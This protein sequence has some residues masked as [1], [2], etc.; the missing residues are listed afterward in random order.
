MKYILLLIIWVLPFSVLSEEKYSISGIVNDDTSKEAIISA[1]VALYKDS[2]IN[3]DNF[4]KGAYSNKFGF[5]SLPNIP[6]GTYYLAVSSVGYKLQFTKLTVANDDVR[7][8]I[9]LESVSV[10]TQELTVTADRES[11]PTSSISSIS[12]SPS[13]VSKMPA[14]GG[15]VD[16][17]R[18]LQLLPGIAAGSELSSG[19]YVRGGSPDQNLIL[20][21][22]VTVYNPSHLAGFISSFNNDAIKD[23][24]MI[25]GA[26]PAEYGGRL[27]SVLDLTMKEGRKD[28]VGG[29]AGISLISSK[30]TVEGPINENSS[31][32][33]SGRR[34]YFDLLLGLI[35]NDA[36]TY[37]F[38]DF[39]AKANYKLSDNDVLYVSGYFARD[40]FGVNE[41]DN[42]DISVNWG[43]STANIRWMHIVNP[44][45][46]T[47]FSLVYTD[48]IFDSN[49]GEEDVIFNTGS[50]IRD[51]VLKGDAQYLAYDDHIIKTGA[52][53]TWHNFNAKAN[54]NESNINEADFLGEGNINTF[55]I[56]LYAQDEWKATDRLDV[57]YGLRGYYFQQGN[58]LDIEPRLSA[59][60]LTGEGVRLKGAFAVA[61]QYIHLVVRN[62]IS[63][64]TDLWF[65]S[66]ENIL[67]SRSYQGV[68][69]AEMNIIDDTYLISLE[70][71]YKKMDNLLEYRDDAEFT[72]GIPLEE[73]FTRGEGRAYGIELFL[74]K[75]IG[76]FTGWVGY[77]LAWTKRQF[78]DLNN[79]KEFYPRYDRRHDISVTL[80]YEFSDV[81]ELGLA[82][83]YGTG[84]AFTMPTS[85]YYWRED[86]D[87]Y[88]DKYQFS[89]RNGV[90]LPAYHRMDLNFMYKFKAYNLPWVLSINI[91]NVYD[92]RN[93]FAWY[94]NNEYDPQTGDYKKQLKQITLFPIIP[95]L[96]LSF[97]F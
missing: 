14:F 57:N 69:G 52:D 15:E 26:F 91:Y 3:K 13:F 33:I 22:G 62:N 81:W 27:S 6:N 92:R 85:T 39:N 7:Q 47:N 35:T 5:Y 74:N 42:D 80:N 55:D 40:V 78:D 8:N 30:L 72:L 65:P 54:F 9:Q 11:S 86:Y 50:R 12:I 93:P 24:R 44:E 53:I 66:T 20:L 2:V 19:L 56:A 48:Y 75:K 49:I 25:K 68:L 97:E 37:Y 71:Y 79:G 59:T 83:V 88:N 16:I 96:G 1:T 73:Q 64:P 60:Y 89:D 61:N 17:F 46:F 31:F 4:V 70:G 41:N 32:M 36:P 51:I 77:T 21:D 45:L 82:W 23:I 38:Y 18:T 10:M 58:Y 43:N 34:F 28:K 67:P 63:L 95:T 94:I 84:Q 76:N 29:K 90:R 87:Y